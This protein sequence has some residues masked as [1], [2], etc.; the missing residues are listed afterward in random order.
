M[1][2][3]LPPGFTYVRRLGAG[4]A[5]AVFVARQDSLAR[6]VALKQL[7]GDDQLDPAAARRFLDEGRALAALR[8][9]SAISVYDIVTHGGSVWLVTQ[10][11]DGQDLQKVLDAG[12][13]VKFPSAMR[14]ILQIGQALD[15][16]NDVGIL[17]RDVKPA[18]ILI[19]RN[20]D[21][22]L[23][24]FGV[25]ELVSS[26]DQQPTGALVGTPAY[27][28]P[29][30]ISGG[31]VDGRSDLYSLA[32]VA[33]QLL[34]GEHPYLP[35]VHSLSEIFT[36]QLNEDPLASLGPNLPGS[37]RACLARALAKS[38]SERQDT[39]GQFC[40]ELE[41]AAD[42]DAPGWRDLAG[43]RSESR[44]AGQRRKPGRRSGLHRLALLV[45][46]CLFAAAVGAVASALIRH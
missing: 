8:S 44:G 11:V 26:L 21:A 7:P 24:D 14:W 45:A 23:A 20:G 28:A 13:S 3:F 17:H 1:A 36:A 43:W 32:M 30:Q 37:I 4:T 31:I 40:A 15:R 18:N 9:G 46:V 25:A 12:P 42:A 39:V 10:Y 16:A 29:E 27:M 19:A 22:F 2:E 41:I 33:L 38:S 35:H 6:L 34:S 5:G